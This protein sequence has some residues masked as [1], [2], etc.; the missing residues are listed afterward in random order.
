MAYGSVVGGAVT[1]ASKSPAW[2]VACGQ[3]APA[4]SSGLFLAPFPTIKNIM[5][6]RSVG[7]LPLLPY[8]SMCVNAFMWTAYGLLKKDS[9]IWS[10]NL[11]GL[12]C[13]INY[14][15]QFKKFCK[16]GASNLPG[17]A[18]QHLNYSTLIITFT[19]MMAVILDTS[20]AANIIGKLGVLFCVILFASPLSTLKTVI[21]TKNASSIPL[22][23]TLT[24]IVNCF[25]W[26]VYGFDLKD[27][28][29]YFPNLLGLLSSL[30]QF[31]LIMLYGNGKQPEGLPL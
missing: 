12:L 25:L 18:T 9:K 11:F 22:P 13:G 16:P 7:N 30:A 15:Y 5:A 26:T 10:P 2:V 6:N 1:V 14:F 24:C 31:G 29:I 20:L 19:A 27:F 17:T 28:N 21:E 3:A 4:V 8:S 23:F